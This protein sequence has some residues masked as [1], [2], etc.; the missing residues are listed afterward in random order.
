MRGK[1]IFLLVVFFAMFAIGCGNTEAAKDQFGNAQDFT[2]KDI[3][4]KTVKLS[5]YSGKVILLNFFATWCPPCR[6]EMPD[7]EE[8]QKEYKNDLKVIAINVGRESQGTV[9]SF[10]EKN[11]LTYTIAMDDGS[12]SRLYGPMPGIPVTVI[13]DKSF[14]IAKRYVG[15][16][17]KAVFESDIKALRK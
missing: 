8:L 14:N 9:K 4:G 11:G 7:F 13:I 1:A 3:N 16:R 12:I 10:A 17:T 15:L 2:V 6:T 5:D